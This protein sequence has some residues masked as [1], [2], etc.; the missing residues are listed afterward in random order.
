[1]GAGLLIYR[2]VGGELQVLLVHPGGPF[3]RSKDEGAWSIP[4]GEVGPGEDPIAAAIR[5][6]EEE[7]GLSPTGP[8]LAL[9]PVRQK[10]GKLVHA[11][12]FEGDCDLGSIGCNTFTIE[13][14]PRSGRHAEFPEIDRAAF[15]GPVEARRKVNAG[16][17]PLIDEL[18]RIVR[19]GA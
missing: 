16:Q 11:W 1:V 3:F 8:F 4:K 15:F 10:G 5:E 6:V 14:P 9:T 18:E 2:R 13:W 17:V 7:I 12:A 19:G